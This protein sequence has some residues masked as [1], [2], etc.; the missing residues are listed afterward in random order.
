M[1]I[2]FQST[3][4]SNCAE[5][6]HFSAFH[7]NSEGGGGGGGEGGRGGG[8]G[9]REGRGGNRVYS[10]YRRKKRKQ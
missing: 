5:G 3:F 9:T 2:C 4:Q 6:L 10:T 8:G 1:Q 7:M